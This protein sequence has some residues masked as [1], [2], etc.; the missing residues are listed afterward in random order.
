M[1]DVRIR[2]WDL[3]TTAVTA[4]G[5]R[6]FSDEGDGGAAVFADPLAAADAAGSMLSQSAVEG[7]DLRVG[8]HTG[9]VIENGNSL[10]GLAVHVAARLCDE[11]PTGST[12]VSQATASELGRS[13]WVV[14]PFGQRS[15]KG[16]DD[17]IDVALVTAEAVSEQE[18]RALAAPEAWE[19]IASSPRLDARSDRFVGRSTQWGQ[20]S[21]RAS[22]A[23]SGQTRMALVR[24]NPGTGKSTLAQRFALDLADQGWLSLLGRTDEAFDDPFQE[25]IEALTHVVAEAPTGLLADHVLRH[26]DLLTRLLPGLADRVPSA[27]RFTDDEAPA[28]DRLLLFEAAADLVR[29]VARHQPVAIVIEDIHWSSAP[30]LDLIRHLMRVRDLGPVLFAVT[31]RPSD[32][33]A[34][35]DPDRFITKMIAEPDVITIDV[36]DFDVDAVRELVDS[37]MTDPASRRDELV[38]AIADHVHEQ[39]GGN[40][41]FCTEVLRGL[42]DDASARA[43]LSSASD[44]APLIAELA[45]P[46]SVQDLVRRRTESMG[47]A[48]AAVLTDAAILGE[49]FA[50]RELH[51]LVGGPLVDLITALGDAER[52]GLLRAEDQG[53][54]RYAFGHALMQAALTGRLTT[55]ERIQRHRAAADLLIE[56]SASGDGSARRSRAADTLRHLQAAGMLATTEEIATQAELAASDAAARLALDDV[57]RFRQVA[58]DAV[59]EDPDVGE[60][61]CARALAS[62]GRAQTAV[63]EL[64]GKRTMVQA[65]ERARAAGDWGL[66]A[67]IAIAYGGELKENQAVFA[68]AEPIALI[69]EALEH[70]TEPTARRADLLMSLALWKRQTTP[71]AERRPLVDEAL[72][73]VGGDVD[74]VA[75]AS[76]LA[77]HHRALHGP[78]IAEEVFAYADEIEAIGRA[79]GDDAIVFQAL[80]IR[81]IVRFQTG[82]WDEALATAGELAAVA[83]R[84]QHFEGR[85]LTTMWR[86]L[87]ANL[88]GDFET[89]SAEI[90]SLVRLLSGYPEED[91]NRL[92]AAVSFATSWIQGYSAPLYELSAAVHDRPVS[93]A[94]FAADAGWVDVAIGDVERSDGMDGADAQLDYLWWFDVVALCRVARAAGDRELAARVASSLAPYRDMNAT[95]GLANF[96]GAGTHHYA[97]LLTVLGRDDEAIASYE[98]ALARHEEMSARPFIALTEAELSLVLRS[99][100]GDGDVA[101]ADALEASARS[102]AAELGL[103]LVTDVLG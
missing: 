90:A 13:D 4:N 98:A 3:I 49:S 22:E 101:R 26:G 85:R 97:T 81:S 12:V 72:S 55:A 74:P 57:V 59:V 89:G 43:A 67:D 18:I 54:R 9:E 50:T 69:D 95:L 31:Y 27:I 44:P 32:I 47:R 23:A 61:V 25:I 93:L 91:A 86:A 84:L 100:D 62:L 17:G 78:N 30:S 102:A 42:A 48:T 58:V 28:P 87:V 103:G 35:G 29:V 46:R 68:V 11:A 66:F 41:L 33:E 34:D 39:T 94:F 76:V 82:P 2:L 5:G 99:R 96:L 52:V 71:Y 36:T 8:L 92:F 45:I 77:G 51:G 63:G 19:P 20:L 73:I 53:G 38:G 70:E 37:V 64:V 88:Q 65:S 1:V 40:A 6:I 80:N 60:A 16:L 7:I 75:R 10:V 21:A 24:G 83:D 15:V 79:R 56:R 14:T